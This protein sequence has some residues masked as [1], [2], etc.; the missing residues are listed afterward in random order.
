[1]IE[2]IEHACLQ[3]LESKRI[4]LYVTI[5]CDVDEKIIKKLWFLTE[6]YILVYLVIYHELYLS[7]LIM[8][9][10]HK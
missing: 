6:H 5:D 7:W 4:K 8:V 3:N 2:F 10:Y 1:M 9:I